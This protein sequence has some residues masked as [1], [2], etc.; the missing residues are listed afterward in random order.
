MV[1]QGS[2]ALR[3]DNR[4]NMNYNLLNLLKFLTRQQSLRQTWDCCAKGKE[5]GRTGPGGVK[6]EKEESMSLARAEGK[7]RQPPEIEECSRTL[8]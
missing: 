1:S 6:K 4:L 2:S 3:K 5:G 7:R 8:W